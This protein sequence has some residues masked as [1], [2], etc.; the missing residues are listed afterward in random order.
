MS[1][2]TR[3][4]FLRGSAG[5][6]LVLLA[7]DLLPGL[8]PT[9]RAA[10]AAGSPP[11]LDAMAGDWQPVS[12]IVHQPEASNFYGGLE[13]D[14][15]ICGFQR[16]AMAPYT[17]GGSGFDATFDGAALDSQFVRWYPYQIHRLAE[18]ASGLRVL[19]GT[20]MAFEANQVL[21]TLA[22]TNPT[23]SQVS[24]TV[25]VALDPVVRKYT[26][27]WDW[28]I[29]RPA[30]Q[31]FT[32]QLVGSAPSQNLIVSDRTGPAV[33]AVALSPA[34]QSLSVSGTG[35]TATWTL[36]LAAGATGTLEIVVAVGDTTTGRPL[37]AASDASAVVAAA[38]T[39]IGSFQSVFGAAET[40]W[41]TRWSDA[42]TPGNSHYSGYLPTIATDH[43]A[44]DRLYYMSVLSVICAERT[45]LG[46]AFSTLLGRASGGF[47]GFPRIY[48]TG[49]NEFGETT[50]FFWDTSYASVVLALLDPAM[51][52]AIASYF[53]TSNIHTCYA[54]DM[55]SG[56]T[57]G[58]Y[59]SANDL[60][61]STTTMNYVKLAGDWSFLTSS[62]GGQSVLGHLTQSATYW[63]SFVP[64]GQHLADYGGAIN[65]LEVL[66]QYTNQVASLNAAN[67]WLMQQ[68]A[69]L[70]N[71]T[72][73]PAEASTLTSLANSLLPNVL[74]L[75]VAGQGVWNCRHSDGTLV[76]V[77]TVV[78]FC[79]G[80]NALAAGSE[81][82]STQR[83]EMMGFVDAELLD[84]NWM[85]ALSLK[86]G[87]APVD[88]PDH[89]STG[90]YEAWPALTAQTF[91]RFGNYASFLAMLETFSGVTSQGPFGQAHQ[92]APGRFGYR[93]VD[94]EALNPARGI[95]LA[96]WIDAA[97]WP[98]QIWQGS[99]IAKDSFSA[100]AGY[101]FRGGAGG[102]LSFVLYTGGGGWSELQSTTALSSG[103]HHVAATYDGSTMSIY[104]D[105]TKIAA[106]SQTASILPS[107]G[108]D[109]VVGDCPSDPTRQFDGTIAGAQMYSRALTATEIAAAHSA[110]NP[111]ANDD[112]ALAL[113][114]PMQ[115]GLPDLI[116]DGP[117]LNPTG[118]ITLAAWID[119]A[120]W[121]AQ[122]WQGSIINKESFPANAGYAFR[123]GAGGLLSF[124][125]Y[126]GGGGWSE[127]QSTTA[128]ASGWHHVA[129]T[130]DGSTM[131]IY[132]DGTKIA[133]KAQT[134]SIYPSTGL[135]AM[136]G[137]C[138]S[139]M[140]RQF[141]GSIDDARIYGRALSSAEVSGI[142]AA[143]NTFAA[144]ADP[145]MQLWYQPVS[146]PLA[147]PP[148]VG[149][150]AN[151]NPQVYNGTEGGA[152]AG[153][154]VTDLFGYAPDGQ[155]PALKDASAPRGLGGTLS[156]LAFNGQSYTIT[157]GS[158]GLSIE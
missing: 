113:H 156:G 5:A 77:R 62:L 32:A 9:A 41:S 84:G 138:P 49:A 101:V 131:S 3:R 1:E 115:L 25:S 73:N 43:P 61:V 123:G 108:T 29:P 157:S 112:P 109:L 2:F 96:A 120:S 71:R 69:D 142:Y 14:A 54:V 63:Q 80:A 37:S 31:D 55:L 135:S 86:D 8:A 111:F 10:G 85:R 107:T 60:T 92:L 114:R 65:L 42:F 132:A 12:G 154:I 20:R 57:V 21:L 103:W 74:D 17:Q 122:I 72:G 6:G 121:P 153:V 58:N 11:S 147:T 46:P 83:Q 40:G 104:A 70:Q 39:S 87:E 93:V 52:K 26:S 53:L 13:A 38:N 7:S 47:T 134:G 148:D 133:A 19:S 64:S 140:T 94:S 91:A 48:T 67:V 45:N 127:L 126:T 75:Y 89:G 97:S 118:A 117:A 30:D 99:I 146:G 110:G 116:P 143:G 24:T 51:A 35:G 34:P 98:A 100:N 150:I 44:V 76:P 27:G 130:Y 16:L 149:L 81:L 79:I 158:D 128:L 28:Q 95:T 22:V 66:P 144:H 139:D 105:G 145:A 78:D 102:L 141:V 119:A 155:Q 136:V 4:T 68:V 36:T 88:R 152:F 124:L 50:M 18:T 90:A 33:S 23:A 129:A 137:N 15:N 106:Q 151:D 59:Y 56:N 82:S 125:I